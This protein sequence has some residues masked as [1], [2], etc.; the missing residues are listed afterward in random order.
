METIELF[1]GTGSF[2]KVAHELGH[3]TFTIEIN[4]EQFP[5]LCKDILEVQR[6][7]LNK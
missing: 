7:D 2:S 3:K 5:N 6:E 1:S 4:E